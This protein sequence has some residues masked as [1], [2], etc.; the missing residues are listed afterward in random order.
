MKA[1]TRQR[2]AE[3]S[4][5][6]AAWPA[7]DLP[8]AGT[9]AAAL[10]A[11]SPPQQPAL[12]RQPTPLLPCGLTEEELA[13][14]TT[15]LERTSGQ[16]AGDWQQMSCR[17][18]PASAARGKPS[19]PCRPPKSAA[20]PHPPPAPPV[21]PLPAAAPQPAAPAPSA[22]TAGAP[23]AV[24]PAEDEAER[25]RRSFERVNRV[26]A[27]VA[28]EKA[29]RRSDDPQRHRMAGH[30]S[31]GRLVGAGVGAAAPPPRPGGRRAAQPAMGGLILLDQQRSASE[32]QIDQLLGPTTPRGSV[33]RISAA[34]RLAAISPNPPGPAP[35]A[36]PHHRAASTLP[37]RLSPQPVRLSAPQASGSSWQQQHLALAATGGDTSPRAGRNGTSA[38]QAGPGQH[39][40]DPL[41]QS[42]LQPDEPPVSVAAESPVSLTATAAAAQQQ[43]AAGAPL[44]QP[45]AA[46]LSALRR[47]PLGANQPAEEPPD[48]PG[49]CRKKGWVTA[50][51]RL[52]RY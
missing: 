40:A 24:A 2:Q 19:A 44:Q 31:Q 16:G 20:V 11:A 36:E 41:L 21:S 43:A 35:A 33:D 25:R 51:G 23:P 39:H 3:G 48:S 10:A 28:A 27:A 45:H 13:A 50:V 52:L 30:R 46:R 9:A 7:Q 12:T 22:P 1:A 42:L 8:A 14:L 37:A 34:Q 4:S 26:A 17:G 18:Q 15:R 29:R 32:G 47:S 38:W 49:R 5:P 6:W